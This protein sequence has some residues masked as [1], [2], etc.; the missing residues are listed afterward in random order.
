M[1]AIAGFSHGL[2]KR[3]GLVV[4]F[5]KAL[6]GCLAGFLLAIVVTLTLLRG[7]DL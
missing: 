3:Q 1:G 6:V 5:V 7:L 2:L 4:A